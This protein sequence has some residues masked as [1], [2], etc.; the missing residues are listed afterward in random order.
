MYKMTDAMFHYTENRKPPHPPPNLPLEGE[1]ARFLPF[2]GRVGAGMGRHA[3]GKSCVT[4]HY[5][6]VTLLLS[7][8]SAM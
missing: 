4:R 1:G 8:C 5:Y 3:Y 6:H 7:H 2:K